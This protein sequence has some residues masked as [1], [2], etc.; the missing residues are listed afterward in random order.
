MQLIRSILLA[1]ILIPT[2]VF[3]GIETAITPQVTERAKKNHNWKTV[4]STKKDAQIVFMNITHKTNPHN[5]LG[6]ETYKFDQVIF[7][8]EGD[9]KAIL[10]HKTSMLKPGDMLLIPQGIP[11]NVINLSAKKPLKLIS[12]YAEAKMPAN[13]VYKKKSNEPRG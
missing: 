8:V 7:I 6:M 10:D 12:I 5:E 3:A 9:G 2:L 11:H 4:F 13:A 1:L